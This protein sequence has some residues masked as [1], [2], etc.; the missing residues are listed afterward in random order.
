MKTFLQRSLLA[1]S[2][3]LFSASLPITVAQ[4]AEAQTVMAGDIMIKEPVARASAGPAKAGASYMMLMNKGSSADV[5]TGARS[6]VAKTTS[7]HTHLME[8]G[9]AK[10]RPAG[11]VEIPAGEMVTF[12]PGGLHVMYIGLHAPFKKG[13]SFPVTLMFEKAGEVE[14]TV[15]VGE[16][17]AGMNHGN[18]SHGTM[19]HGTMKK[20]K[21]A[22]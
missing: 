8:D 18:M 1:L 19:N 20:E 3:A 17:A 13:D 15:T 4:Q 9:V 10:M 22:E 5:L 7:I 16:V 14:I 11:P 21:K 6:D 2:L 12:Q